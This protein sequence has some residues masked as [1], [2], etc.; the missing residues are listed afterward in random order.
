MADDSGFVEQALG[1]VSRIEPERSH[2]V[3]FLD[4]SFWNSDSEDE[5]G[6]NPIKVV[7]RRITTYPTQARAELAAS[8]M[9]RAAARNQLHP[10]LGY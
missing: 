4:V 5:P 10:P 1:V 9:V 8:F 7:R 2:W 3:V 6:Y